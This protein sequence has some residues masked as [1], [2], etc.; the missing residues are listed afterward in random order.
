MKLPYPSS[1]VALC[2]QAWRGAEK[3]RVVLTNVLW[4]LQVPHRLRL[5]IHRHGV[6]LRGM[7]RCLP[8]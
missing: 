7:C 3:G 5:R 6:V 2:S 4:R 8:A 1:G